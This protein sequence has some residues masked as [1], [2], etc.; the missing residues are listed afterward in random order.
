M[1][2]ESEYV[3][4]AVKPWGATPGLDLLPTAPPWTVD[5]LCAQTDPEAFFPDKGGS[6]RD[7][8]RICGD[9]PVR[10]ECL[11]Y[12]LENDEFFG[13]WGG[14]SQRERRALIRARRK[15]AA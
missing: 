10:Q 14:L 12:A 6:S 7:A 11:E 5:A 8:K 9:C 2:R 1:T 15:A 3:I 4:P 13:I